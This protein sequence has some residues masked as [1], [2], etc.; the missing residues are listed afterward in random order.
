ME[1]WFR[2]HKGGKGICLSNKNH[3]PFSFRIG[4]RKYIKILSWY[5][6]MLKPY[7]FD[8]TK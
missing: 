2:F 1:Y 4:K 6:Y 7:K 3:L 8:N 5:I